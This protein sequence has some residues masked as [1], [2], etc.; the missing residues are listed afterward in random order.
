M[1]ITTAG[2]AQSALGVDC[3]VAP[4]VDSATDGALPAPPDADLSRQL[5]N[6]IWWEA[7]A[8]AL[9]ADGFSWKFGLGLNLTVYLAMVLFAV[10]SVLRLRFGYVPRSSARLLAVAALFA[11]LPTIRESDELTLV[12]T[13]AFLSLVA[14]AA[15]SAAPVPLH[16]LVGARVRD[17]IATLARSAAQTAFGALPMLGRLFAG[18]RATERSRIVNVIRIVVLSTAVSAIFVMLLSA[19]DPVFRNATSWLLNWSPTTLGSHIGYTALFAWPI[20]GFLWG[21]T[22]MVR[23]NALLIQAPPVT[24]SLRKVDAASALVSLNVVFAV[25]VAFQARAFFGGQSYVLATTGLSLADYARGGFF[26]LIVTSGLVLSVLLACN[27]LL[28]ASG[29]AQSKLLRRLSLLLLVLDGVV[30][31]SAAARMTIYMNAFGASLE[32]VYAMAIILWLGAVMSWFAFTVLRKR[33]ARFVWGTVVLAVVTVLSLNVVSP[34]VL[35]ARNHLQ[36]AA[37]GAVHDMTYLATELSADAIPALV[38]AATASPIPAC[39]CGE[40]CNLLPSMQARWKNENGTSSLGQWSIGRWR[41]QRALHQVGATPQ[42]AP[43]ITAAQAPC[44]A[45]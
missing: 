26:T 12:N 7:L 14:L 16:T 32:R 2:L 28:P 21:N 8:C 9:V 13:M 1:H 19:G 20:L 31:A 42:P 6:R 29:L 45:S 38:A 24:W 23:G 36:R 3:G 18:S 30:L 33:P 4:A 11:L 27:A 37:R 17:V 25:F 44:A 35:V 34:D 40:L 15:A 43:T 41:A 39:Q 10:V 5:S 22:D